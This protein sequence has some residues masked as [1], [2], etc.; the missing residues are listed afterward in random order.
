MYLFS[1]ALILSLFRGKKNSNK[2]THKTKAEICLHLILPLVVE[3]SCSD[4]VSSFVLLMRVNFT[5]EGH[6]PRKSLYNS[7]QCS[8]AMFSVSKDGS[9]KPL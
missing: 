7:L 2:R 9:M 6:L 4:I 8:K 5:F 1:V 3:E